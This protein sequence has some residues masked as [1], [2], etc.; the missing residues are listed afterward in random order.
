MYPDK[1]TNLPQVTDKLYHIMLHRVHLAMSGIDTHNLVVIG[2]DCTGSCK[3]SYH[4][5]TIKTA[6]DSNIR[7]LLGMLLVLNANF[8]AISSVL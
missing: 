2:T 8:N 3:F 6:L 7:M 1:T 4:T 5:I